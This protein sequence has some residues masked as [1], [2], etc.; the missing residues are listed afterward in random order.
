MMSVMFEGSG[1][2]EG[3]VA[4]HEWKGLGKNGMRL[5]DVVQ[6]DRMEAADRTGRGF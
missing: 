6:R 3:N 5:E 1:Y 4:R 2:D